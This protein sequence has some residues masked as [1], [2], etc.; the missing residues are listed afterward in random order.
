M[1]EP[2]IQQLTT[3]KGIT[4]WLV[5]SHQI[6]MISAEV[7]FRAGS[8]FEPADKNGVAALTAA[9]LDEGAGD[10]DAL[11]FKEATDDIGARF[12][13]GSDKMDLNVHLT[14]LTD[15]KTEAFALLREALNRPRFDADAVARVKEATIAGIRQSEEQPNA[16]AAKNFMKA[17]YGTHGYGRPTL[18][19]ESTVAALSAADARTWHAAQIT[20][21]NMV[22]SVVGDITA[23]ALLP[24]IDDTLATLPAGTTRNTMTDIP[25]PTTP[26]FVKVERQIPQSSVLVGHLGLPRD[27]T[28]FFALL[29]MNEILGGGALTSRLGYVVREDHG[30]AYDVRSVN[31]PMPLAG[32]FYVQLQ[33]ENE[34]VQLALD[35]VKKE[36]QRIKNSPVTADEFSDTIDYLVGSF[37]LRIDSNA[38]ILDYLSLMQMEGL[39]PTYL[40]DWIARIKAVTPADV[41]RV[42]QRLIHENA[43]ALTVVGGTKA[44]G[45]RF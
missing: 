20:R 31:I 17:V 9:L 35:L 33:T 25:S 1:A 22:V 40:Q 12:G 21:A 15:Y 26:Q 44:L 14:T 45:A 7:T 16:V 10:M 11:A 27:D 34:K 5:E 3:P 43:M 6:P 41:Q 18:G 36:L 30:L 2:N 19:T 24:L 38:K 23:E 13:A 42:A 8:A 37:P 32:A 39:G 28:D 29:V 4:V